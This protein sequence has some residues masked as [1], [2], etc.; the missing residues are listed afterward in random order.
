MF[1]MT[2][3]HGCLSDLDKLYDQ[4]SGKTEIGRWLSISYPQKVTVR[5]TKYVR[6]HWISVSLNSQILR[7]QT[8]CEEL[9]HWKRLWCWERLNAG[10]EGDR[11]WDGWMASPTQWTCISASSRS[12]WWTG[13][14]GVL[15][16]CAAVH[17]SQ[18]AGPERLNWLAHYSDAP[19][20]Y[21]LSPWFV[22]NLAWWSLLASALSSQGSR[23]S[24]KW[25][26]MVACER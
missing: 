12:W 7:D 8:W 24:V 4:K 19:R 14:P 6:M 3:Y 16:P 2:N 10:G 11:G 15:Q 25:G 13:R 1:Y 20:E 5:T 26:L 9:T 23:L 17:E 21:T 18:R 22:P